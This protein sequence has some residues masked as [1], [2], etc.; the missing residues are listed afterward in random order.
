[1]LL[2][3]WGTT[4]G[5]NFIYAHLNR[6]IRAY[7]L[8]MIYISGPGHGGP[9]LVGNAYLG[10]NLSGVYSEISAKA[11]GLRKLFMQFSFPGGI[12]C[13]ASPERP[14]TIPE[15]REPGF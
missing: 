4:P 12:T 6:I 14:R 10:G 7:G 15:G 13:H 8:N 1:M 9:A 2:G 5:Q 11:A 3:H